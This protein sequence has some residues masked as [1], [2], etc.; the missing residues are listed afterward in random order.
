MRTSLSSEHVE[1]Y[2]TDGF[3]VIEDFLDAAELATWR[4]AF[5]HA[6]TS[7]EAERTASQDA[8]ADAD[9]EFYSR[10]FDQYVNLWQ[11]DETMR[12]L[13]FDARIAQCAAEL[14]G[15]DRLRI[16]HDQALTKQPYGNPT[17]F[18]LDLPYWP[19]SARDAL[20]IWI[21]LDDATE[22]NGGLY[23]FPGSHRETTE[24]N[25]DIGPNLG[26]I[27]DVYPQFANRPATSGA[28][29]AGSC[30]FHNCMTIHGAGANMTNLARRAMFCAYIPDGVT[31]DGTQHIVTDAQLASLQ[32]GDPIALPHH[33]PIVFATDAQPA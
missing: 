19:F 15:V 7:R 17:A 8:D 4:D 30:S 16:W 12:D 33:N 20:S 3:V 31:F 2:R 18:H 1:R 5:D 32:T 25:V 26:A 9:A 27:F 22:A 24:A 6:V 28:M 29:R 14:A 21:A 23:F 10:V 13:I 11:S